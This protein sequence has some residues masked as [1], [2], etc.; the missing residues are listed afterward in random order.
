VK[1]LIAV[2]TFENIMPET[3]KSIYGLDNCGHWLVFDYMRGYDCA[4]ARNL[5]AQEAVDE[6]ADYVLMVDNDVV[7]PPDA[8]ASFLDDPVDVC[9]GV[10]PN[11]NGNNVYTGATCVCRLDQPDGTPYY[12]YPTESEYSAQEINAMAQAGLKKVRIHG[13]GFGCALVRTDVFLTLKWPW[14]KWVDYEDGHGTLSE[15]L[16][17]CE[18][19][20]EAGIPVYTDVRVRCGHVFR[21]VQEVI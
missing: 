5:I 14:F 13:G 19:C 2:P 6:G 11:R 15:D 4:Q 7:L 8:I 10:Y 1:I 9:L 18:Q 16:Y 21:R 3:F 20:K 17:F 12:H